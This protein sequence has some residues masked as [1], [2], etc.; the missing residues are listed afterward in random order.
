MKSVKR[1]WKRAR[2]AGGLYLA[3]ILCGVFAEGM[4]RSGAVAQGDPGALAS[5][6]RESIWLFRAGF[7]ADVVMVACDAAVALLLYELFRPVSTTVSSLSAVFR[8]LEASILGLNLLH[9]QTALMVVSPDHGSYPL[10]RDAD[11]AAV[12]FLGLHAR[13]YDLALLFF[14]VSIF[15]LGHL[16]LCSSGFPRILGLGLLVS[17][18]VYAAGSML[19]FFAPGLLGPFQP[20][21]VV[22]LLAETAFALHLLF[23]GPDG[24]V[25]R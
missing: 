18:L 10:F 5:R 2:L 11:A 17:A 23:K 16:V 12:V 14:A 7:A 24:A 3:I 22:P 6:I 13:G 4:V 1:P 19:R 8:L 9:Y 25:R 20:T 21:Y 15:A